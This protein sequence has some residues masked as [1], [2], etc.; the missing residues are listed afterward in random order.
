MTVPA[1]RTRRTA[2]HP[3]PAPPCERRVPQH[4]FACRDHW[5]L[6]PKELR[7]E[8]SE[9]WDERR[10]TKGGPDEAEAMRVHYAS[11]E[12]AR[13]WLADYFNTGPA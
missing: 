8:I 13:L 7:V 6:L 10:A 5:F 1:T 4:H 11:L 9:A 3:C 12:R 2:S